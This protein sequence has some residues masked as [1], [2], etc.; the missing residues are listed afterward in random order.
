[1]IQSIDISSMGSGLLPWTRLIHEKLAILA[2]FA[3][4]HVRLKELR[5]ELLGE[6]RFLE[7]VIYDIPKQVG[8]QAGIDFSLYFRALDDQA[9][10]TDVWK[11][12]QHP[13]TVGLLVMKDGKGKPLSPREMSNTV[14]HAK[15]IEWNLSSNPKIID[16]EKWSRA[17]IEMKLLLDMGGEL[18]S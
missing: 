8:T 16:Q 2:T 17:E 4:S 7:K 1:M 14:I 3:Y 6:R 18:G 5:K 13:P 12:S 10:L 11:R 9:G 15:S